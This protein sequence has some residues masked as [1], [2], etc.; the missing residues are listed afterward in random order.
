[1]NKKIR[2]SVHNGTQI[3][4]EHN[5]RNPNITDKES[6]IDK[7]RTHKNI[8]FVDE[9]LDKAYQ[10]IFG[11]AQEAYNAK[12]KRKDR[13]IKN[14]LQTIKEDKVKHPVYEVIVQIGDCDTVS[15]DDM[16]IRKALTAYVNDWKRR[17]PNLEM[18]GAY[19]HNDEATPHLHI[20]YI[21]V[22]HGY[23]K[24]M[25]TQNG[26]VRALK[27][28]GLELKVKR[29]QDKTQQW[30]TAQMQ[31]QEREREALC[32][33]ARKYSIEAVNEHDK[34]K[35]SHMSVPEYKMYQEELNKVKGAVLAE[36]QVD[37]LIEQK[38]SRIFSSI[39]LSKEEFKA[40]STTARERESVEIEL[41]DALQKQQLKISNMQSSY[42]NEINKLEFDFKNSEA[43]VKSLVAENNQL[44]RN[45]ELEVNKRWEKE[46]LDNLKKIESLEK[47]L[48]N[49]NIELQNAL[50]QLQQEQLQLQTIVNAIN[51][52]EETKALWDL[53]ETRIINNDLDLEL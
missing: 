10:R 33:I 17:N 25:E 44:K 19:L 27:E 21:P 23:K 18:I 22:A 36:Q 48:N 51:Y 16:A 32:R 14:Y 12:Q 1:M 28:Q 15:N 31:W 20:D 13:Q 43:Q 46:K 35:M 8:V 11:A 29:G 47:Q 3:A 39:K 24:G 49:K 34:P 45:F 42:E 5:K 4:R 40:L 9:D 50:R 2:V 38:T 53:I 7:S 37:N 30:Q 6:H 26:L 41:K 52:S